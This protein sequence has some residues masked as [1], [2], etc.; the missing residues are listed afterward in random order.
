MRQGFLLEKLN[1]RQKALDKY[2]KRKKMT[3]IA[4][5]EKNNEKAEM[6]KQCEEKR[7]MDIIQIKRNIN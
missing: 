6:T 3:S 1:S 7:K 4:A 5:Q 2:E